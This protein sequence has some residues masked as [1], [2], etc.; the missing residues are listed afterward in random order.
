MAQ[1]NTKLTETGAIQ[2]SCPSPLLTSRPWEQKEQAEREDMILGGD[3]M[4]GLQPDSREERQASELMSQG[5]ITQRC[6]GG[7]C[8]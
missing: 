6:C 3:T 1:S 2:S 8:K 5:L 7:F 4:E